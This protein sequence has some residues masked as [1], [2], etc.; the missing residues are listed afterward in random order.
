[1]LAQGPLPS[2]EEL[3][4][5]PLL[6]PAQA[7]QYF[8]KK[9]GQEKAPCPRSLLLEKDLI[10]LVEAVG[11]FRL[12]P[13]L[14][15]VLIRSQLGL[16]PPPVER[17]GQA[18]YVFPDHFEI[19]LLVLNL[20]RH[21]HLPLAVI[22]DLLKHLSPE[23]Y[24]LILD[25]KLALDELLDLSKMLP[26]GF[27]LKDLI[28]AKSCDTMIQDLLPSTQA[29]MAAME[30]GEKLEKTENDLILKRLEEIKK[31][32]SSERKQ[33]FLKR[34]SAED[35]KDLSENWRLAKKIRTKVLAKKVY[36]FLEKEGLK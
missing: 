9:G 6:K 17:N 21:Y 8:G 1:M 4:K 28:I 14:L 34:E 15:Q 20:R 30:P 19:L 11:E 5:L 2:P 33:K 26:K 18:L 7:F 23:H 12:S 16:L 36:G 10:E 31:W 29:V 25:H 24:H 27:E 22:Q 3:K 13:R 35:F 32:V